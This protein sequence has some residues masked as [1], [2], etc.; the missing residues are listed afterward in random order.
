MIFTPAPTSRSAASWA[1]SSGTAKTPTMMLRSRTAA[2][3]SDTACT[4][5]SPMPVPILAGSESKT[6]AMLN[7]WS[8]NAGADEHDVVLSRRP[9]DLA[10]LGDQVVDVVAHAALAE[11]AEAGQVAPDLGGVH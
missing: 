4:V 8:A 2:G 9:Q 3:R 6:P 10:D 7:P 5:R 1:A 11:L